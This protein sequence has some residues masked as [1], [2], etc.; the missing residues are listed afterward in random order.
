VSF[1]SPFHAGVRPTHGHGTLIGS[2]VPEAASAE[3]HADVPE[4][5]MFAA[6][7]ACVASAPAGRRRE[8][9]TVRCCARAAL[10][11]IGVVGVPILPDEQ[12]VPRWPAGVVGSM[13]HCEGY[14]AAAVARSAELGGIGI[15]AE[16][17]GPIPDDSLELLLRDEERAALPTLADAE[18][19]LHWDR[20]AFCAKEAVFKAWFPL[21][22]RWLDFAD[23][24]T[25]VDPDGTFAARLLVRGVRVGDSDLEAFAGRWVVDR[26]LVATA[27]SIPEASGP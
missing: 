3:M 16:P 25:T 24:S 14:R 2:V 15:D 19:R 12:R 7:A 11:R 26:G 5:T 8:F 21:T 6:E 9:A 18:P 22:R 20:I 27:T 17:H 1:T 23:V 10:R 4:P 13:T